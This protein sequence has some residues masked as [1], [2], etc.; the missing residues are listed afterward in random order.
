MHL[1]LGWIGFNC[2][3]SFQADIIDVILIICTDL[4]APAAAGIS[5]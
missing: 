2:G 5:A 3:R 1:W 4:A